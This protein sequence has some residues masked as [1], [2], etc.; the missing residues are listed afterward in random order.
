MNIKSLFKNLGD[1]LRPDEP[2]IESI[3]FK[4]AQAMTERVSFSRL[5]NY[6]EFD[7]ETNIMFLDDGETPAAGFMLQ[8]SP[9]LVA[10]VDAEPQF[11][12]IIN[13]CPP[14]TIIQSSVLSSQF[15]EGFLDR[16]AKARTEQAT[17]DIL[18]NVATRRREFMLNCLG[19]TSMLPKTEMHPRNLM[20]FLS[21]RVPFTGDPSRMADFESFVRMVA[22]L[23][24]SVQGALSGTGI[25]SRVLE[26]DEVKFVLRELLNPHMAPHP[27]V[28]EAMPDIP[29]YLDLMDRNTRLRVVDEGGVAFEGQNGEPEAVVV[30][31][32]VDSYPNEVYLPMTANLL[33]DPTSREDRITN[34]F[35]AYTTIHVLDADKARDSLTAKMGALNKQA[36]S[37]SEWYRAMMSHMYV[38]REA[39]QNLLDVARQGKQLVRI[40]T[41][42]N[43][44]T[45]I[46]NIKR[47]TEYVTALWRRAGFRASAEKFITLPAF[48]ASLPLQYTPTMDP[49]NRG[50]QRAITAH[51]INA[52]SLFFAQGDWAGNDPEAGGPLL[53]SRRGQLAS[54]NLLETSTNYNF[55][56]VA[57]SGSGKSFFINEIVAD[58]LARDG[59][60]RILDVGRSYQRTCEIVG[61]VN[62]IF[63]PN[64]PVSMNPFYGIDQEKDL[65][66]MLP[67]LKALLR[68]MAYPLQ[69]EEDTPSWEYQALE[70]AVVAAWDTHRETTEL[71]HVYDWLLAHHD[72]RA[73]DLAFQLAPFATGRYAPWFTGARQVK[74]DN[75]FIVVEL[76]E[77]NTDPELQS[78]VLTLCIHQI[79]KEMYLSDVR[80]PK[81]LAIDEAWALLGNMKTGAF[82]E[83]AF[84]RA[85]KYNGIAGVITQSFEDF[86]RSPA[87]RAAIQNAAWKFVLHQHAESLQFAADNKLILADEYLLDLLKSVKSGAGYSEVYVWSEEGQGLYRFITD[88]HSYYT[89]TTN[90]KDKSR[91]ANLTAQGH[92]MLESIDI[93]AKEDYAAGWGK[94]D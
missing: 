7:K 12:A 6:R 39:T 67:M 20:Y 71:R 4:A 21:V 32:T 57:A 46:P 51:S 31:I 55:I 48:I 94:L 16:W 18:S 82:I 3:P 91:M 2:G 68:Q 24:N 11:E 77:L 44:V 43:I 14:D 5:L 50:M 1:W 59:M 36:M 53:V 28:F 72:T 26:E 73:R 47:D 17:N 86:T 65:A 56:V 40:Y 74:F 92:T 89:F 34:P 66:E 45:D 90:P 49:P 78:V 75:K 54:F 69:A 22:D 15:V 23:Q 33:G 52:A 37:E 27:R 76:E 13:T 19:D 93:L 62:L 10:G 42:I 8:M 9:L 80:I 63:D 61:G 81:L 38:K 85:R 58:F 88:R 30:P 79:T 29:A 84:R 64:N 70:A 87:A 35:W 83:T 41:G 25:H 60:V